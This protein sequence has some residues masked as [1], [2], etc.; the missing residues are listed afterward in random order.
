MSKIKSGIL[1]AILAICPVYVLLASQGETLIQS[2]QLD[3]N[4]IQKEW[5]QMGLDVHRILNK[6]AKLKNLNNLKN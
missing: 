6:T 1:I 5:K 2:R 3:K 4:V